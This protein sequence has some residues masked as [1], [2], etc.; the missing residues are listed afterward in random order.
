MPTVQVLH[1]TENVCIRLISVPVGKS[2]FLQHHDDKHSLAIPLEHLEKD[3]PYTL[4]VNYLL[5]HSP[6]GQH[7]SLHHSG[8][9]DKEEQFVQ[10][11]WRKMR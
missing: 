7:Y 9:N 5:H 4:L 1:E 8:A 10:L 6:A 2:F 11:L 3:V